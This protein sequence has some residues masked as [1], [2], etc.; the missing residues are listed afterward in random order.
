MVTAAVE[1]IFKLNV[2]IKIENGDESMT[3]FLLHCQQWGF[4]EELCEDLAEG[5]AEAQLPKH[6]RLL[7]IRDSGLFE[8]AVRVRPDPF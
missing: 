2:K 1:I 3:S 6:L 8:A 5:N 4:H 7:Q